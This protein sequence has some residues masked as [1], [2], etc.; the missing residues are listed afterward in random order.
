MKKL[1]VTGFGT[2]ETGMVDRITETILEYNGNVE[3]SRMARLA[4]NFAMIM[5]VTVP[6]NV[7]E[8]LSDKLKSMQGYHVVA[9]KASEARAENFA[10]W[11]P[12]KI[13]V[14]GADHRGIIHKISHYLARKGIN[15]ESMDTR[16]TEAPMSG[17]PLFHMFSVIFASPEIPFHQLRQDIEE[18]GDEM[19]V[20]VDVSAY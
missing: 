7:E 4:G 16:I 14:D 1:I 8:G 12:Y 20:E 2:D 9:Q 10:G 13:Q 11:I 5:L 15:V 6:E 18:L 19:G 3:E 17:T